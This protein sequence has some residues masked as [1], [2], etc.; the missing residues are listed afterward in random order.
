MSNT[1][2]RAKRKLDELAGR[3]KAKVG[4]AIGNEQ[5][6][7]EGKAKEL[8]AK[9]KQGIAKSAERAKGTIEQVTGSAKKRVGLLIKNQQV[10]AEGTIKELKGTVR[11]RIHK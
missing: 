11:A 5:M 1:S 2:H 8:A 6:Q 7:L 9:A 3:A 10:R 4:K